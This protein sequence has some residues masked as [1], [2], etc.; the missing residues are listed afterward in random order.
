M[1]DYGSALVASKQTDMSMV[2]RYC[3]VKLKTRRCIEF[4]ACVAAN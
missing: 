3:T 4:E 2:N 1:S